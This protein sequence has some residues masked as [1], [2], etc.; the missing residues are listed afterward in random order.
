MYECIWVIKWKLV[1]R[2]NACPFVTVQGVD[3]NMEPALEDFAP[4]A[5]DT[6]SIVRATSSRDYQI[7]LLESRG[8]NS[9][10]V[11][12]LRAGL[13]SI[14]KSYDPQPITSTVQAN[15]TLNAQGA[16]LNMTP[17]RPLATRERQI[18]II[19]SRGPNS[20]GVALLHAG[21]ADLAA[22]TSNQPDP[23]MVSLPMEAPKHHPQCDGQYFRLYPKYA[24]P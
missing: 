6:L 18:A 2:R 5:C 9:R 16:D 7:S 17:L 3:L 14:G 12:M 23:P 20:R 24:R 11:H 4:P 8:P 21:L 22:M 1:N 10:G 15:H 13:A 19:E